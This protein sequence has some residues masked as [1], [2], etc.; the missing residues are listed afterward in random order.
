[1][2]RLVEMFKV[3]KA[4]EECVRMAKRLPKEN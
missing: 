4:D 2:E 3:V 1:V